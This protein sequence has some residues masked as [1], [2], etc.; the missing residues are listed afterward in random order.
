MDMQWIDALWIHGS[1]HTADMHDSSV[2]MTC[3][4]WMRCMNVQY[5]IGLKMDRRRVQT[6]ML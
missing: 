1:V 2:S 6:A 4:L 3:V 5:V